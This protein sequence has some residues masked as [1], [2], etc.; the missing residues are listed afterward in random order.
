MNGQGACVHSACGRPLPSLPGP[1]GPLPT[2]PF[3]ASSTPQIPMC[4]PLVP[5]PA[6][7]FSIILVQ[8]GRN[9]I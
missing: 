4:L 6:C 9:I 5:N 7:A 2:L 3:P 8:T 1:A